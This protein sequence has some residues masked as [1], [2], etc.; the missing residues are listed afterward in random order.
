MKKATRGSV[1]VM[2]IKGYENKSQADK[3]KDKVM[4]DLEEKYKHRS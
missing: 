4:R 1:I 2:K 3:L